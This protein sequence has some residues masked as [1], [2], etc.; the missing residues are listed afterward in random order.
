MR[1]YLRAGCTVVSNP[2]FTLRP[3][4]RD[5]QPTY[6]RT[7]LNSSCEHNA[8]LEWTALIVLLQYEHV[9]QPF[10]WMRPAGNCWTLIPWLIRVLGLSGVRYGIFTVLR[11]CTAFCK[12][13]VLGLGFL[14][15][16]LADLEAKCLDTSP[17][18]VLTDGR[19]NKQLTVL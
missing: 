18:R 17:S 12:K 9:S 1:K 5:T 14:C 19:T 15:S 7:I 3:L 2:I 13:C 10:G 16:W 6:A 4:P 8:A 11:I